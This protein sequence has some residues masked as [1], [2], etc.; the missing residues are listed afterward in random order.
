MNPNKMKVLILV[1]NTHHKLNKIKA[2]I[3]LRKDFNNQ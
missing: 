2:L 3:I 1:F